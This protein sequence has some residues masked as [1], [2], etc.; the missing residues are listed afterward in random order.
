[1]SKLELEHGS[2][3]WGDLA[4]D[5]GPVADVDYFRLAQAP[6]SSYE[7]VL[8]GTSGDIGPLARL[9]RLGSDNVTVLQT[10]TANGTGSSVSLRWENTVGA[11]VASQHLRVGSAGRG[12]GGG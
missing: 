4:A 11:A 10:G 7:V 5:P 6:L 2:S 8:D 1:L 9:E 3:Q 12:G